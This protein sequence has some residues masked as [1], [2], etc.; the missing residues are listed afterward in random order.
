LSRVSIVGFVFIIF[1]PVDKFSSPKLHDHPV[2]ELV[3]E[4]LNWTVSGADPMTGVALK[5]ATGGSSADT[6][7]QA[8]SIRKR[9]VT[10]TGCQNSERDRKHAGVETDSLIPITPQQVGLETMDTSCNKYCQIILYEKI[11]KY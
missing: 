11:N 9:Q 3:E 4:S 1:H 5:S 6:P 10:T 7:W 2:G 8:T